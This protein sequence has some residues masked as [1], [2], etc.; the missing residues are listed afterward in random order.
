M[1]KD[2]VI[3]AVQPKILNYF[4]KNI[5]DYAGGSGGYM[6]GFVFHMQ[7]EEFFLRLSETL[8]NIMI[9]NNVFGHQ[10]LRLW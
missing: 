8:V 4:N 5:F 3:A 9:Q 1:K 10:E 2:K 6:I 7:G